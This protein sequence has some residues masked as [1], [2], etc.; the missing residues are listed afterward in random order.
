M[1]DRLHNPYLLLV[2]TVLFWSGNMVIGRALREQVPPLSLAFWRWAIAFALV[3]PLALPHLRA[4]W[5]LLRASWKA[6]SVLGLLGV[7]GYNTLAYIGLQYTPA[8]NAAL[9]NSFIPIATITL[10]W[11]F[12]GKHLRTI[13]W[14]GVLISFSGVSIIVSRGDPVSLG[15]LSFNV[16]DLW[17][18]VAVFTWALYTIGLQWRPAAVDP[19]L[20][21]AA[22]TLVG[23]LALAPAYAWELSQGRMIS[24]SPGV[25]AGIAYTGIFPGFLGYVFYNR[26]VGEVGASKASLFLHL[27]PVFATILSAIFLAET[28]QPYHYLGIALIFGGIYM[29][30][31]AKGAARAR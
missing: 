14:L 23:L 17:M 5:P 28:P 16:G 20:L 24:V 7:G 8:T 18:L 31:A 21:L 26:A 1:H 13:D 3:L 19:M 29:T 12:L 6:V 10:S 27:M 15:Q 4:Q 30:T 22:F 9:L 11:A 25:L 2:L